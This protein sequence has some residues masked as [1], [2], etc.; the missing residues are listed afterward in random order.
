[1]RETTAFLS[2]YRLLQPFQIIRIRVRKGV[3]EILDQRIQVG[4]MDRLLFHALI[5][6]AYRQRH[7]ALTH[8]TA[9]DRVAPVQRTLHL[10]QDLV[11]KPT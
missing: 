7:L 10:F 4:Q 8:I 5:P 2:F 3:V 6:L 1:M 11:E 9:E